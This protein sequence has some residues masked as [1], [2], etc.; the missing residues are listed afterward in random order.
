MGV[1]RTSPSGIAGKSRGA[2]R[3][4]AAMVVG[5]SL[6]HEKGGQTL[7]C[8]LAKGRSLRSAVKINGGT[9]PSPANPL[10]GLVGFIGDSTEV[11]PSSIS[12][13]RQPLAKS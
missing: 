4:L 10:R 3:T 12:P 2:G 13:V 11:S 8:H 9:K 7:I 5:C 6:E 1:R